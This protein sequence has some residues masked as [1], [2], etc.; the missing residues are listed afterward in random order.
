MEN[1][2]VLVL[3]LMSGEHII[4]TVEESSGVYLCTDVLQIVTDFD[5]ENG[6]TKSSAV[7][8]M[9]FTSGAIGV[10]SS[11]TTMAIPNAELLEHYNQRFSKIISPTQQ[12]I[13]LPS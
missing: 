11:V 1:T 6:Q 5:H 2:E 7:P 9:P 4:A 3:G 10:P 12:K 8:Y 13:I